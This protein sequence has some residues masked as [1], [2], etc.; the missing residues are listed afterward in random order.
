MLRPLR[1]SGITFLAAEPYG[2]GAASQG[3]ATGRQDGQVTIAVGF[4]ADL[5]QA[6]LVIDDQ[7]RIARK[8][9]T[10]RTT[11]FTRAFVYPEPAALTAARARCLP[12]VTVRRYRRG[13]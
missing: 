6:Q 10:A 4:P 5:T 8:V 9:L 3:A 1:M 7:G 13:R 11:S 2:A 12:Q